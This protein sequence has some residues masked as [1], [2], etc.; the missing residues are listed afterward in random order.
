MEGEEGEA[1]GG[2]VVRGV[3]GQTV[4]SLGGRYSHAELG[5]RV[6]GITEG[7]SLAVGRGGGPPA[8]LHP[9]CLVS[10]SELLSSQV[11]RR[12]GGS[13]GPYGK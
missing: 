12:G 9:A 3:G 10:C 7:T 4:A 5:G 1:W 6:R 11:Q 8:R 2:S 13:N